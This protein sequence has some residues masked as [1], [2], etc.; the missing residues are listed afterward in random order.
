[1]DAGALEASTSAE[2]ADAIDQLHA[3]MTVTHSQL[4]QVVAEGDR[5]ED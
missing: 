4:L 2:R 1:V 5:K 3:L